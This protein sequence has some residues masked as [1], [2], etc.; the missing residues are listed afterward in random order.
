MPDKLMT[1]SQTA[2][3]LQVSEKTVRRL[4]KNKSLLASKVSSSWRIKKSDIDI[5][6]QSHM[7]YAKGRFEQ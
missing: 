4:I 5:Y 7:N 1:V 2:E 6:L 3:Y